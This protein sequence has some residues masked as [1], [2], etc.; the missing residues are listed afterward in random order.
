MLCFVSG[1]TNH[2]CAKWH[3]FII[4]ALR[5]SVGFFQKCPVVQ[6][7]SNISLNSKCTMLVVCH[8]RTL[9]H[10]GWQFIH[11]GIRYK[12]ILLY[13][14]TNSTIG[15]LVA[16]REWNS[17]I[18]Y[19]LSQVIKDYQLMAIVCVMVM[20]DVLV[21]SIWEF[22]DPLDVVV[23]NKTM[24]YIVIKWKLFCFK[25]VPWMDHTENTHR[26]YNLPVEF[27]WKC[28]Q[29]IWWFLEG[30]GCFRT[31]WK[32]L[33]CHGPSSPSATNTGVNLHLP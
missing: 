3:S 15:G 16:A 5:Q 13:I 33:A 10:F 23:Y 21:L 32:L 7:E 22:I 29:S 24:E 2:R 6:S 9:W 11:S 4:Q 17:Y 1:L 18:V 26:K 25:R 27:D 30:S 20:L 31:T 19:L 14:T 28:D 12:N 8:V